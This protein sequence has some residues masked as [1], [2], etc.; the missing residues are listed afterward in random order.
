MG[1][2]WLSYGFIESEMTAGSCP[3]GH[4]AVIID[5]GAVTPAIPGSLSPVRAQGR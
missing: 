2:D 4:W 1:R 5:I 3:V